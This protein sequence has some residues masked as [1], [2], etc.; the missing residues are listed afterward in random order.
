MKIPRRFVTVLIAGALAGLAALAVDQVLALSTL[1]YVLRLAPGFVAAYVG[2][3]AFF[4]VVIELGTARRQSVDARRLD[5]WR[6]FALSTAAIY[7]PAIVERLHNALQGRGLALLATVI[8]VG[9]GCYALWIAA[10]QHVAGPR[11]PTVAPFLGALTA[12][13]GLAVN[14]NVVDRPL[15][16]AAL[17]ADAAVLAG[18]LALAL[19][20]RTAGARGALAALAVLTVGVVLLVTW[21]PGGKP[22]G[23]PGGVERPNLVLVIIDT[24]RQDVFDEVVRET[25]EGRAFARKMDGAGWFTQAIA[26]SP[27][28]VP[29][30]GSIMTGLFPTEHG[31][32][33]PLV[34]RGKR[35]MTPLPESV[36]TLAEGLRRHGY[37]TEGL[38]TNQLLQPGTGIARGFDHYEVLAGPA[39]KLPLLTALD[40][41]GLIEEVPYERAAAVR[42]RLR[43]RL[44]RIMPSD[45]PLFLWL[46]LLDPHAP[47]VEHRHLAPEPAAEKLNPLERRYRHEVRY[48]L[49]ELRRMFEDLRA[50]GLWRDT[51]VVVASDHGEMFPTD[52]H[53]NGVKTLA[54]DRPK[55]YGHGH[56]LY[57]E[58]A[59]VPLVIRPAGGLPEP[60][61]IDALT[62][63]AD[64]VATLAD[65]LDVELPGPEHRRFS[66]A[67][68]LR[69]SPPSPPPRARPFTLISGIQH[70]PRQR[71]LR[72]P[73]YKLIE[74]LE[75]QRPSELYLLSRDPAEKRDLAGVKTNLL[76]RAQ[77]QLERRWSRLAEPPEIEPAE[78][79]AESLERL[80]A[81]GYL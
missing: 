55:L 13:I 18:A 12:A 4:A 9:V 21:S 78:L 40:R 57:G 30:V 6:L 79:D 73:R 62:G 46:H 26:A 54:G 20:A 77:R 74:Y 42:H 60:R 67:P 14:R 66:L 48:A 1:G 49:D 15:E 69:E 50:H 32:D 80:K 39:I 70:G 27:W 8:V 19:L 10:L 63:H 11:A 35:A 23:E 65:L 68:W 17:V 64:L 81:L 22:A 25:E 29:S 24:L 72:T 36:P 58:L 76:A 31:Y 34:A 56:A 47:L 75:G 61:R 59:R 51:V 16:P 37:R 41:L 3:G 71:A 43:Q 5:A 44:A 38:V 52:G 2:V 7:V 45:R 53:D 33:A 28:T